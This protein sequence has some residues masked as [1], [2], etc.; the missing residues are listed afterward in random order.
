MITRKPKIQFG[1]ARAPKREWRRHEAFVRRCACVVPG[2]A[3]RDIQFAHL[4]TAANSGIALK[5]ASWFGVA[6]CRSHHSQAHNIGH[7][8]FARLYRI[9][10]WKLAEEFVRKSPDFAMKR[11]MREAGL[12]ETINSD[13]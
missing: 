7:D 5:P 13:N 4:R 3:N 1:I 2:C 10:L 9:D 6:L 12:T 11:A 8:S